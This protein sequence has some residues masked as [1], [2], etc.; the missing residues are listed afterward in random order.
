MPQFK[1]GKTM[2]RV[3]SSFL[4][5]LLLLF[6]GCGGNFAVNPLVGVCL[7]VNDSLY[8]CDSAVAD[9]ALPSTLESIGSI[10]NFGSALPKSNFESTSN[11][12]GSEI[13]QEPNATDKV[14]TYNADKEQ[15]W[16]YLR[17]DICV[18]LDNVLYIADSDSTVAELPEGCTSVGSIARC[19]EKGVPTEQLES[20]GIAADTEIFVNPK[21]T[22]HI[23]AVKKLS[24]GVRYLPLTQFINIDIE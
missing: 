23:Y 16:L 14:Y 8:I 5:F 2:K 24:N 18:A 1:G 3:I 12:F 4:V 7:M 19:I 6:C 22:Q 17:C 21:D 20:L 10:N 11:D 15:H 13:L 9:G